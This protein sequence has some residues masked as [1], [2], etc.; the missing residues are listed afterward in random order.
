LNVNPD[1]AS[2]SAAGF[3]ARE[4]KMKYELV[5]AVDP[6]TALLSGKPVFSVCALLFS[7]DVNSWD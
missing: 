6:A 4:I 2:F 7:W 5:I 1:I 3:L